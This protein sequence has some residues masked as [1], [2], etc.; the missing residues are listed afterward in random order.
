MLL[1]LSILSLIII[2]CWVYT[3]RFKKTFLIKKGHHLSS[4]FIKFF[5]IKPPRSFIFRVTFHNSWKYDLENFE[6]RDFN[7]VIGV[8]FF[9]SHKTNSI[10]FGARYNKNTNKID[11]VPYAYIN[12]VRFIP[13]D[14]KGKELILS[15]CDLNVEYTF[16]ISISKFN[17]TLRINKEGKN[18]GQTIIIKKG[19]NKKF[20][21][22]LKPFFG[23]NITAPHDILTTIELR[24]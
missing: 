7:K 10:R 4:F 23:G 6:Q 22:L 20:A 8:G 16:V 3:P 11:V 19:H 1:M 21:Y 5:S 15:P 17:Y 24:K 9:P 14:D 2:L 13:K 12:K 18:L